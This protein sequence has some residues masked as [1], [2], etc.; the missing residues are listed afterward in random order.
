LITPK[1]IHPAFKHFIL[2]SAV[3]KWGNLFKERDGIIFFGKTGGSCFPTTMVF[4]RLLRDEFGIP[5]KEE[6]VRTL[7]GNEASARILFE[8][9]M[10]ELHHEAEKY[11]DDT[12]KNTPKLVGLGWPDD[13]ERFHFV[14]TLPQSHEVLD[15]TIQDFD[16]PHW[17]IHCNNYWSKYDE[18]GEKKG[19]FVSNE[20][21][22]QSKC[23][24]YSSRKTGLS[25]KDNVVASPR[26]DMKELNRD[27]QDFRFWVREQIKRRN[28]PV[29]MR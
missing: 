1:R 10:K 18:E 17:G 24:L 21:W 2:E 16:R 12:D 28:V 29:F 23:V 19:L 22:N 14:M 5:C 8:K 13:P 27:Y 11:K 3:P 20:I 4:C 26:C 6:V 15:L 25:E 7:I 9:G